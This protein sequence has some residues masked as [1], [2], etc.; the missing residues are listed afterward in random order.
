VTTVSLPNDSASAED[1]VRPINLKTDLA[2]L[3]DLIELVFADSM[4]QSGLAAV[5]EMRYLSKMSLGLNLLAGVNDLAQGISLGHVYIADGR[6]VG[7]VSIYP[8]NWKGVRGKAWIIANVGVHPDYQRRGIAAE[9]MRASM[10]MIRQRGG[11]TALLQVDMTN[12]TARRLYRRLGFIDERTWTLW[13][14]NSSSRAPLSSEAQSVYISTRRRS[15]W[16]AEYEMAQRLRP[17]H[18]GGMG[19]QRPLHMG[20]FRKSFLQRLTDWVS[21]R[22][23]ERLVIRSADQQRLL[24]SLWIE[25]S[26]MSGNTQLT[27]MV[28]PEYAGI[29]DDALIN[30]ATRSF[31]SS[32]GS[33][34]IE[35]PSDETVTSD[36]LRNYHFRPQREVVHMRWDVQP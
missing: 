22:S 35:H 11:T 2:P 3:A 24:A 6:L 15:E 27:L 25:N 13:R 33:L 31:G 17:A 18:L 8:T 10:D 36:V 32:R 26:F 34:V 7:N 14:R 29:Y 20:L 9:L 1:G 5:R 30:L 4:D 19:W 12:D 21:F 28:E 16:R 23:E